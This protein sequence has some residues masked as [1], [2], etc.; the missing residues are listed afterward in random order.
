MK[1]LIMHTPLSQPCTIYVLSFLLKAFLKLWQLWQLWQ[2]VFSLIIQ[3][4][5]SHNSNTWS[6]RIWSSVLR[7][8]MNP[9][10]EKNVLYVVIK[11]TI[12]VYIRYRYINPWLQLPQ[13]SNLIYYGLQKY[14]NIPVL[15]VY[16]RKH[17]NSTVWRIWIKNI[18]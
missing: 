4:Y 2:V 12:C 14:T 6:I 16:L 8:N 18:Y 10:S 7:L 11:T 1:N 17:R 9:W 3:M 15:E 5:I 13:N